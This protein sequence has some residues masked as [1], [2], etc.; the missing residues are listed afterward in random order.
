MRGRSF[1][2][3]F[4]ESDVSCFA[5]DPVLSGSLLGR[6]AVE[7]HGLS[8]V[9]HGIDGSSPAAFIAAYRPNNQSDEQ[10]TQAPRPAA[11]PASARRVLS[12]WSESSLSTGMCRLAVD[13]N[14]H[15][16]GH[17]GWP[18]ELRKH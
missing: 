5:M 4:L 18:F 17:L 3:S 9:S 14:A 8:L 6:V 15:D 1:L 13:S 2:I 11:S 12:N 16:E 7:S 10:R